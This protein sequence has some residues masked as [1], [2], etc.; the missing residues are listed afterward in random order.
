MSDKIKELIKQKKTLDNQ[1]LTYFVNYFSILM[2]DNL[3]PSDIELEELILNALM[4]A[5]KIVFYDENHQVY[6][7][8]GPDTKGFRDPKTKTIFIRKNLEEPLREI[9]IYHE[10][11]HATQTNPSN[12]EVGINQESNIGRLIMEA[13]TQYI[14]EKIYSEI[15]NI[16]FEEK[17]INSEN[18]RMIGNGMVTSSLHNY[19]L[20]DNL[21][22]KLAIML[23]VSKD[24]FVSIN[25]LYKNNE[26]LKKL[27]IKYNEAKEKYQ[28]PYNF[29]D[30]LLMLDY[31][32][33]VDLIGYKEN[34]DKQNILDGK[35]TECF[36]E[37]YPNKNFKLSLK[38]QRE[39]I[40]AF[41]VDNFLSLA[42]SNGDF[43]RF[44]KYIIDNEKRELANLY[45]DTYFDKGSE[46]YGRK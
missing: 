41:D 31:I 37:I 33:C 6:K 1:T 23:D 36:Y 44:S 39:Y 4:Y 5:D 13:E 29:Y 43:K 24:Y 9:T 10:L 8:N 14:A 45:I 12:D 34:P 15:H 35:E 16:N 22:S 27:E 26:G 17:T 3:I 38:R 30:L 46:N 7:E 42:S 18:L 21:L 19:E 25:F 2:N 40:N 28:L 20:Y 32:Y 11:H